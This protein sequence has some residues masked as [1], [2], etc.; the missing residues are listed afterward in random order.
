MWWQPEDPEVT[1]LMRAAHARIATELG[2]LVDLHAPEAWGKFKRS[3]GRPVLHNGQLEWLRVR[4]FPVGQ[5]AGQWQRWDDELLN[6]IWNG[7]VTATRLPMEVPRPRLL[8]VS[9]YSEFENHL[10][11]RLIYRGELF[12][13]AS[14]ATVATS[15]VLNREVNLPMSW[16]SELR[17]VYDTIA[18]V[19]LATA[20]E[21]VM[22]HQ[23]QITEAI[24]SHFADQIDPTVPRWVTAHGD[25]HWANL[26]APRL[27]ILDWEFWGAAPAG[28]DAAILYLVTLH[29]PKTAAR[30]HD[31]FADI[32]DSDVGV[33]AQVAFVAR[34][35]RNI[36]LTREPEEPYSVLADPWR[37]HAHH[38]LGTI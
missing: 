29:L 20:E 2:V 18:A 24:S 21:R 11:L 12:E 23:D 7:E 34:F 1:K 27:Q 13:H 38:L 35:L 31:T 22:I 28:Y 26:T 10:Q 30:V 37:N 14:D 33:F 15:P 17:A 19:P 32:L 6:L 4:C 8:A 3:L 25:F 5:V 16:W 36:G 9:D